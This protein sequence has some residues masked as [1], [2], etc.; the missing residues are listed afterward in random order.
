[1]AAYTGLAAVF[2]LVPVVP[3]VMPRVMLRVMP[4]VM[5]KIMPRVAPRVAL[6]LPKMMHTIVNSLHHYVLMTLLLEVAT[7]FMCV[8]ARKVWSAP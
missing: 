3:R 6:T 5:L 4:R 1:M 2:T 8:V 7:A